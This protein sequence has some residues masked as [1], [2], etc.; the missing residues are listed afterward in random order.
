[1]EGLIQAENQITILYPSQ[2]SL[3]Q[4]GIVRDAKTTGWK[5]V[6]EKDIYTPLKY[7]PQITYQL[8]IY[9]LQTGYHLSQEIKLTSPIKGQTCE[10]H[11][12]GCPEKITTSQI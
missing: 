1:M 5:F 3:I 8:Q 10:T 11:P 9:Q 4:A 6:G 12:D 2:S 7:F